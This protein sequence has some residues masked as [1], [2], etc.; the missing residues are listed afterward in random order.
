MTWELGCLYLSSPLVYFATQQCHYFVIVYINI[1][2]NH[3]FRYFCFSTFWLILRVLSKISIYFYLIFLLELLFLKFSIFPK[4]SIFWPLVF[5]TWCVHG[6]V[7]LQYAMLSCRLKIKT[8][9]CYFMLARVDF[10]P[11]SQVI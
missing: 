2:Y 9:Y 10:V 5:I 7:I 4:Y 1:K 11:S 6:Y 3:L 8:L